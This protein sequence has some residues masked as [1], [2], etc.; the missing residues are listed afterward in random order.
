MYECMHTRTSWRNKMLFLLL[1]CVSAALVLRAQKHAF[2]FFP[3]KN[4]DLM[5]QVLL[6]KAGSHFFLM[7]PENTGGLKL[8]IFDTATQTG[9]TKEYAFPRP[10]SLLLN[11]GS[12]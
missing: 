8:D 5:Q 3:I 4:A 2:R 1:I 12:I 7:D 9:I 10:V 6:G 11:E